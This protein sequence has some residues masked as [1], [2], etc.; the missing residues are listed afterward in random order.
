MSLRKKSKVQRSLSDF[1][2]LEVR[3][4]SSR[5][6]STQATLDT[7]KGIA[8]HETVKHIASKRSIDVNGVYKQIKWLRQNGYLTTNNELTS[9]GLEC[10]SG[11]LRTLQKLVRLH[12]LRFRVEI[13]KYLDH[14]FVS[15]RREYLELANI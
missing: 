5:G 11:G 14:R 7:L 10:S 12:D 15:R 8:N 9:K 6:I 3:V 2:P 13:I 4:G 1:V